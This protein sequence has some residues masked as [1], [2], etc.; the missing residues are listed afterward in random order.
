MA[1]QQRVSTFRQRLFVRF[2]SFCAFPGLKLFVDL[3]LIVKQAL[4]E[5]ALYF[6]L[7]FFAYYLNF[8]LQHFSSASRTLIVPKAKN[9]CMNPRRILYYYF[10]AY[11]IFI[12][13]KINQ[14]NSAIRPNIIAGMR[15]LEMCHKFKQVNRKCQ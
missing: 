6:C 9:F 5:L 1:T 4:F 15:P 12:P 14:V 7:V 10:I 11:C 3:L 13:R 8:V 2:P